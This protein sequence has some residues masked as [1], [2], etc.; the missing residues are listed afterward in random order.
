[1]H[2]RGALWLLFLPLAGL[3][4]G[5]SPTA[6]TDVTFNLTRPVQ[7]ED[8]IA[9]PIGDPG[10]SENHRFGYRWIWEL[11]GEAFK[12]VEDFSWD[13]PD[14][15]PIEIA[16][17]KSSG[18]AY[19]ASLSDEEKDA[20]G[21]TVAGANTK[22]GQAWRVVVRPIDQHD[23]DEPNDP[24]ARCDVGPATS[25]SITVRNTP[26]T[27]SV[28]ILPENAGSHE[29]LRAE[30]T[31]EDADGDE[32]RFDYVWTR[33]G[34]G[35]ST[36]FNGNIL[37]AEETRNGEV[38]LVTATPFDTEDGEPATA[39]LTVGNSRPQVDSIDLLWATKPS[40]PTTLEDLTVTGTFSDEDGDAMVVNVIWN[41]VDGEERTLLQTDTLNAEVIQDTNLPGTEIWQVDLDSDLISKDQTIEVVLTANDGSDSAPLST[42]VLT[43]N[44]PPY[45]R[46]L[47]EGVKNVT[48]SDPI[49]AQS[50]PTCTYDSADWLDPDISDIQDANYR[51]TW[52]VAGTDGGVYADED[53][54]LD[55]YKINN[56][57]TCTIEPFDGT[58]Y[59]VPYESDSVS[60]TNSLPQLSVTLTGTENGTT[61][62]G[63]V[64]RSGQDV[65]A[66]A[67]ATDLDGHDVELAYSWQVNGAV[68]TTDTSVLT[69]AI[70][71]YER[72][73]QIDVQVTATDTLGGSSTESV[74]ALVHNSPPVLSTAEISPATLYA[75]SEATVDIVASDSDNDPYTATYAWFVGSSSY[76]ATAL[77]GSF[78]RGD[79]VQ[80]TVF[81]DDGY[82]V[83]SLSGHG[84]TSSSLT[85]GP[86]TVQDSPPV[87]PEVHLDP[88]SP[89]VGLSGA[90]CIFS[91]GEIPTDV[92]GD[93]ITTAWE[94]KVT[95]TSTIKTTSTGTVG[96]SIAAESLAAG[97]EIRCVATATSNG[98]D[99]ESS[100][101]DEVLSDSVTYVLTASE[102]SVATGATDYCSSDSDRWAYAESVSFMWSDLY[103]D[104]G[105]HV[106]TSVSVEFNWF[107]DCED[108]TDPSDYDRDVE[109]NGSTGTQAI[110][111]TENCTCDDPSNFVVSDWTLSAT[112]YIEGGTNTLQIDLVNDGMAEST[113]LSD[114]GYPAYGVVRVSY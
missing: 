109:F 36:E 52:T 23:N 102:F 9:T 98:L 73:D 96:P 104:D 113:D 103:P 92:D 34:T 87:V 59:G 39:E 49:H 60:V 71:Q 51:I 63:L 90:D 41:R 6:L 112:D 44:S 100:N 72:G 80:V 25:R 50:R 16:C 108:G 13:C 57:I 84:T 76:T 28:Y 68:L 66:T 54:D 91:N 26:P 5:E 111:Q 106:P 40:P 79:S 70:G 15:A 38:W 58:S 46:D 12:C 10:A 89:I 114:D 85:H 11:D 55:K 14:L 35:A 7:G 18:Q 24:E 8:L 37:S 82:T 88:V 19:S 45:L 95:G 94:L 29:N 75:D 74:S 107:S 105:Y 110:G 42:S 43:V 62:T 61:S 81:L 17:D 101:D 32:V 4:C 69:Q 86:V 99:T 3:G 83:A 31:G 67:T 65:I 21:N 2:R 22:K 27:A 97:D 30:A 1:M 20:L 77:S 48:L 78:T 47:G 53:F 33:K 64:P 56:A 93:T